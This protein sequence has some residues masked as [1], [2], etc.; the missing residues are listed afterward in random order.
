[1]SENKKTNNK[2]LPFITGI[3]Y[4]LSFIFIRLTVLI[5]GSVKNETV[6]A[7]KEGI[8][9]KNF[10]IGRNIIIYG[11]HIHHFYFGIFLMAVAGWLAIMGNKRFSKVKLAI[12]YGAGLGL[13][14]DEIGMLLSEGD[15]F[16]PLSYLLGIFLLGILINIIYFPPFWNSVRENVLEMTVPRIKYLAIII[17]D[18]IKILDFIS[19]IIVRYKIVILVIL[20]M[21]FLIDFL[22]PYIF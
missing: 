19:S 3:S 15:Y 16:S 8:I 18:T 13:F 10:Y 2:K 14:M 17:K 7:I 5:A 21:F 20:A 22:L 4:L 1:M 12:M 9:N 6:M 11:Y